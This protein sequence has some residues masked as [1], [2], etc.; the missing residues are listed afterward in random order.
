MKTLQL[1]EVKA[2]LSKLIE[3]VLR[4]EEI[5]ISRHGKPV[6]KLTGLSAPEKRELGFY[7][8]VFENDLL[9]PTD[10]DIIDVFYNT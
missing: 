2:H 5:I 7:P 8:I 6:A 4:G 3:E 10:D 1:H 9:E